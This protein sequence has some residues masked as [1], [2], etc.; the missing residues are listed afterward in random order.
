MNYEFPKILTIEEV[1][2]AL[3]GRDEFIVADRGDH[4]ILN[5]TVAF[6]DSFGT[7][8][9]YHSQ[10]RR[11]CRG[12]VFYSDGQLMSRPFHKFFNLGEKPET[13]DLNLSVSH[14]LLIKED[15]SFIRP[16]H[17]GGKMIWGTK[18]GFTE[19]GEKAT[20]FA[21]KNEN[22]VRFGKH[23]ME[24]N[25][26]PIFEYVAPDNKIVISY[27]KENLILLAVRD[28]FTGSYL[29]IR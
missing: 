12:L 27:E 24:N 22:Y 17:V 1:L 20:F 28:N 4:V 7:P 29:R 13:A 9:D 23:C 25:L 18:M 3:A 6:D 19:V 26:T 11:E 14:E 5:Y 2:P 10:L 16:L 15:G 8:D 21:N